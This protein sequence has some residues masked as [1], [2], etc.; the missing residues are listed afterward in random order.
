MKNIS[1]FKTKLPEWRNWYTRATQNRV[2]Q[3]MWVQVP[4]PAQSEALGK[5][6]VMLSLLFSTNL[7]SFFQL[8]DIINP[9]D[10][11][12]VDLLH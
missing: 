2:S 9:Y 7:L 8:D 12:R 11:S 1:C 6:E 4:P 10:N 3:G 5:K